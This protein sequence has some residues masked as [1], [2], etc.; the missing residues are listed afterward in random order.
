MDRSAYTSMNAQEGEHWWFVARRAIIDGLIR[1]HVALPDDARIL[2]AGC[3]TGGNLALLAQ[4]GSVDALEYDDE[5]RASRPRGA[6]PPW[7]QAPCRRR[8]AS[9]IGAMT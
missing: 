2:E 7:R 9:A 1:D 4:H 3:G 6:S 5:A 8:S